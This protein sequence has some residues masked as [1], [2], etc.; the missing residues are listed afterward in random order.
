MWRS[1]LTDPPAISVPTLQSGRR[2]SDKAWFTFI[3][4]HV[5]ALFIVLVMYSVF[6]FCVK[7]PTKL[8]FGAMVLSPSQRSR[9]SAMG[10][11]TE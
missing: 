5:M 8:Q 4:N 11:E 10:C 3:N 2:P 6:F 1:D 7:L 9:F